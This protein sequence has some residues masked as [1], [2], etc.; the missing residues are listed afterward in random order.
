MEV[1][2]YRLSRR[3]AS[4]YLALFDAAQFELHPTQTLAHQV[5]PALFSRPVGEENDE[6]GFSVCLPIEFG[7]PR[8]DL[9]DT[10]RSVVAHIVEMD[11]AFRVPGHADSENPTLWRVTVYEFFVA[12][13]YY[14]TTVN[15]QWPE[16][17]TRAEDGNWRYRGRFL[18]WMRRPNTTP[19]LLAVDAPTAKR[20]PRLAACILLI[21]PLSMR[22]RRARSFAKEFRP[23]TSQVLSTSENCRC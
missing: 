10:A 16:H 22:P 5:F 12:L 13:E 20:D 1:D 15:T 18:P 21:W 4:H 11:D 17:F 9:A 6:L 2:S 19:S 23:A 3:P 7:Q 8:T 14:S